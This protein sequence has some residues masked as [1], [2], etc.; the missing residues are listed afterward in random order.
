MAIFNCK[1]LV[2]QRVVFASETMN[3]HEAWHIGWFGKSGSHCLEPSHFKTL[4]RLRRCMNDSCVWN[5]SPLCQVDWRCRPGCQTVKKKY[6]IRALFFATAWEL[7]Y[8]GSRL[9]NLISHWAWKRAVRLTSFGDWPS[10][11]IH[12]IYFYSKHCYCIKGTIV[13]FICLSV[14]RCRIVP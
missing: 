5:A 3:I 9:L 14:F 1:L 6:P 13:S 12:A 7:S 2:H 10:E 11:H 4:P 8:M